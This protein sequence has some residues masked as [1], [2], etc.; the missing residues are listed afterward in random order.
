ML[1]E[2]FGSIDLCTKRTIIDR[3]KMKET[4]VM[5]V[6]FQMSSNSATSLDVFQL[7]LQKEFKS[8]LARPMFLF[9]TFLI[10]R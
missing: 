1:D 9:Q 8:A 10:T 2:V 7:I 5:S 3:I 4:G 6:L